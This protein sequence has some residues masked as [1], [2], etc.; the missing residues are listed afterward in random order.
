MPNTTHITQP[1]D[2]NYGMFKLIYQSNLMKV[3]TKH[4]ASIKHTS[5]PL[6][7]FSG[8]YKNEDG[9]VLCHSESAF[10]ETFLFNRNQEVWRKLGFYPFTRAYL[11]DAKNGS[12]DIEADPQSHI[13]I[14]FEKENK[15]A[16]AKINEL[17]GDGKH[18]SI[19]A[20]KLS[21]QQK[22]ITITVPNTRE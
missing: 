20:P 2:Q 21:A 18:L 14:E 11:L 17:G 19:E 10:D 13:L 15:A 8:N 16:V 12:V 5:I 9:T 4:T 6:L 1:T 22:K 3:L 7:V